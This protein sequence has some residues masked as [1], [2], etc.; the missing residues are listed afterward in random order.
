[1]DGGPRSRHR[2]G[3]AGRGEFDWWENPTLDLVPTL[4]QSKDVVVAVKDRSAQN[5]IMR[6]NALYPPFDDPAI[7]RL[8]VSAIDQRSFMLA[9]GGTAPDLLV[10]QK[11]GLFVPG[12]PMASDVGVEAMQGPGDQDKLR[13]QLVVA[14]YRGEKIVVL[15][16][17]D[18]AQR[19]RHRAGWR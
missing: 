9:I 6:F 8:V 3:G 11:V 16:A 19:E 4:R 2:R 15:A 7:R 13:Q 12:T 14:G 17:S 5:A 10:Q 1:M 18:L